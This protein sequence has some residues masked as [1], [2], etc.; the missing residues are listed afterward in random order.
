M[1]IETKRPG[2]R[3]TRRQGKKTSGWEKFGHFLS[4]EAAKRLTL[5]SINH[6]R[7]RS[8][9]LNELVLAGLPQYVISVR[10]Q[11]KGSVDPPAELNLAGQEAA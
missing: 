11:S 9:I 5:E 3:S 2:K 6:K 8:E 7:D 10:G 4:P 1:A